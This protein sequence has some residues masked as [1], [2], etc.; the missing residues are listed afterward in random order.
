MDVNFSLYSGRFST[1]ARTV[2]SRDKLLM[3]PAA[4][5]WP[6]PLKYLRAISFTEKFPFD[7]K[8]TLTTP[9]LSL[10]NAARLIPDIDNA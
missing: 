7:R 4:L 10:N 6:P 8:D 9:S 5:T 2:S 3:A 1:K